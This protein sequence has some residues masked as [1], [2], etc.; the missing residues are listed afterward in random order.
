MSEAELNAPDLDDEGNIDVEHYP[1][2]GG[3]DIADPYLREVW[4]ESVKIIN[5]EAESSAD[6]ALD[7]PDP[8]HDSADTNAALEPPAAKVAGQE[9]EGA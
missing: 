8:R 5:Q 6:I 9:K 4:A 1:V 2:P 7:T 3:D